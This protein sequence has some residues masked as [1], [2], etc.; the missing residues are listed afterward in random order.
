MTFRPFGKDVQFSLTDLQ[1]E[2]N[3]MFQRLWQGGMRVN[4][5]A[6][7]DWGP[8]VDLREEPE[9]FV[10]TAEVPGVDIA[11]I[12]LSYTGGVLTIRGEKTAPTFDEGQ[13]QRVT[14]ERRFGSFVRTVPLPASIDADGISA[15]CRNGVLEVVLPK[16]HGARAKTISIETKG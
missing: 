13:W 11:G 8:R 2:M 5:F 9:R 16:T 1:E 7:H 10:L 12:D 6:E 4:P 14:S 3:R 15:G